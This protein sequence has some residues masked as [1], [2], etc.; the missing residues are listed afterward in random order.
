M[1]VRAHRMYMTDIRSVKDKIQFVI[2]PDA[3]INPDNIQSFIK[4][5]QGKM[6]FAPMGTP[7]FTYRLLLTGMVEKDAQTILGACEEILELMEKEIYI[8]E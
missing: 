1:R 4:Q 2:R 5:F 7:T 3:H 8:P 6:S